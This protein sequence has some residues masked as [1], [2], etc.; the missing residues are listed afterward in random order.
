MKTNVSHP[1]IPKRSETSP[2]VTLTRA[3]LKGRSMYA[4]G[5]IHGCYD[6]LLELEDKISKHAKKQKKTPLIVCVGDYCD[7]GPASDK[8]IDH[9]VK[10]CISGTHMGVLGNHEWYFL[11]A[12]ATPRLEELAQASVY[13]P[14]YL[15]SC[16]DLFKNVNGKA[17]SAKDL[18]ETIEQIQVRWSTNGG[19]TTM[20]SYGTT[21]KDSKSYRHIPLEHIA[22]LLTH[23]IAIETPFGIVSHAQMHHTHL[24]MLKANQSDSED[25][26]AAMRWAVEQCLWNREL[27]K[28]PIAE[29]LWHFSGHTPAPVVRRSYKNHWIRFDTG[30]V[31][32]NKLTALHMQTRKSFSVTAHN[33]YKEKKSFSQKSAS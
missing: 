16:A 11:A 17:P 6:E 7:R 24:E 12:N 10:G 27:P 8:V 21:L 3:E 13:W 18:K 30:C 23:P 15:N 14:Y 29:K 32:G 31:Y 22:L 20:N 2:I 4:V 1:S 33:T 25:A 9:I 28:E 19:E 26:C 5:D